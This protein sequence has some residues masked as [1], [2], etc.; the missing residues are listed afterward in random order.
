MGRPPSNAAPRRAK[1]SMLRDPR[2]LAFVKQLKEQNL[3]SEGDWSKAKGM[4]GA[5]SQ[6]PPKSHAAKAI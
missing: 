2:H 1:K 4:A 5:D 6:E 3:I